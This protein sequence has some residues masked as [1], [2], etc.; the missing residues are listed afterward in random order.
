V[1]AL[2][3]RL[4]ADAAARRKDTDRLV[5]ALADADAARLAAAPGG[6]VRAVLAPPAPGA[7]AYLRAVA[8]A[9]AARGR[10]ALLGAIEEGRAHLAFARPKGG[11]EPNLGER[12][13]AAAAALGGKGG[14]APDQAQ[15][16]GPDAGK[17][18]EALLQAER[19]VV[20]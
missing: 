17:L 5:T 18:E 19:G 20:G 4:V 1:P 10:I 8:A 15:G 6:P 14:G 2:V 12:V 11:V 16:S 7:P 13:R 9:L 3:A